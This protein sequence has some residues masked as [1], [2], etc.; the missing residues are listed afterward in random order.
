MIVLHIQ[1][2]VQ[3][4]G[5]WK[6][7]F[8]DD[9]LDRRASGIVGYAVRRGIDEP[10][11]ADIE[12]EFDSVEAAVAVRRRLESMWAAEPGGITAPP[13]TWLLETIEQARVT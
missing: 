4:F 10:L 5:R 6:S 7:A 13:Y 1:H 12:L 3:D 11:L 8:D 2:P 9:P